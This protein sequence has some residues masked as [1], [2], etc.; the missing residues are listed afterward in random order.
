MKSILAS[1]VRP[2][3]TAR[4]VLPWL[5]AGVA[6]TPCAAQT[7]LVVGMGEGGGAVRTF[8]P[9]GGI[10]ESFP[11]GP[12]YLGGVRVARGDVTGDRIADIVVGAGSSFAG[13]IRLFDGASGALIRDFDAF[14]GGTFA[15][16]VQIAV[17]DVNG[18]G[19]ADIIAG[20]GR[21]RAAHVKVFDGRTG[22][23]LMEFFPYEP[24]YAGGAFVAA[25]DVNGDG[26]ADIAV[27]PASSGQ[28]HV[29]VFSGRD[30]A[31][32][33]EFIAFDEPYV[34]DGVGVA[35]ADYDGDGKADIST[36]SGASQSASG[37][38]VKVFDGVTLT[39]LAS[40][41]PYP[42][43]TGG[44]RLASGDIN[45]DGL[46]DVVTAAGP[47]GLPRVS[48][49]LA[50]DAVPAGEQLV[51]DQAYSGGV[52]VALASENMVVF[53]DGFD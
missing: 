14:P 44:G 24:A 5:L 31:L 50:P 15:G 11:L 22:D 7:A 42:G 2:Q 32:L 29:T 40:F 45:G 27:A 18:D 10:V 9:A 53:R 19:Q 33:A 43:F 6:C 26:N 35:M 12:Q 8:D 16:D 34:G 41:F 13:Q 3:A 52:V 21:G 30:G 49:F 38:H 36:I 17:G 37:P 46:A 51:F 23:L 28:P 20:P 1:A 47:G 48:R 39:E 25:G 4:L